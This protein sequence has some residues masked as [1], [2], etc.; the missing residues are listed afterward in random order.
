MGSAL[1]RP[2]F[3]A[4]PLRERSLTPLRPR[5]KVFALAWVM[6]RRH[7]PPAMTPAAQSLDAVHALWDELADFRPA[8][9]DRALQ[10]LFASVA[11][12]VGADD[13]FWMGTVRM[14]RAATAGDPCHGCRAPAIHHW[15]A[16]RRRDDIASVWLKS[17]DRPTD[18]G[19]GQTTIQM[20]AEAGRFRCHRLH[21]R[22][23]IDLAAFRRTRHYAVYYTGLGVTDRMWIGAPVNADTETHF[24]F[25][26][27]NRGAKRFTARD[28]ALAGHALRGIKWFHRQL[29]LR[30]GV[31]AAQARLSPT[32]WRVMPCLLTDRTEKEIAAQLNLSFDA[33]HK[34]ARGIYRKFSVRGRAGLMALW[35][36]Q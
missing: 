1:A 5:A 2:P 11:R 17:F 4:Q 9:S 23:W 27:I 34:H 28:A 18:A 13:A 12:L 16:S 31:R 35:A 36:G 6:G 21:E 30:H 32:E 3:I 22:G 14:R 25:D 8:D 29:L 7:N 19:I 33:T 10:H 26:R 24:V 20:A 15:E